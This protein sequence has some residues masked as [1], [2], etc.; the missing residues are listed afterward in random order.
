MSPTNR[1]WEYHPN[2]Y[3]DRVDTQKALSNWLANPD[4]KPI[5][6]LL[7][8]VGVGKS[9]L[10]RHVFDTEYAADRLVLRLNVVELADV[11]RHNDLKKELVKHVSARCRGLSYLLDPGILLSKLIDDLSKLICRQCPSPSPLVLVDGCDEVEQH[12]FAKVEK[13]FFG[14]FV[15]DDASCFRMVIARRVNLANQR[16]RKSDHQIYMQVLNHESEYG[17]EKQMHKAIMHLYPGRNDLLDFNWRPLGVFAYSWNHPFINAF[18]LDRAANYGSLNAIHIKECC[19]ALMN[20]SAD[21]T[22]FMSSTGAEAECQGL[23]KLAVE[24]PDRWTYEQFK[25][26]AEAIGLPDDMSRYLSRGIIVG[27]KTETRAQGPYYCIADGLREL[28]RGLD[29]LQRKE[30]GS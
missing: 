19:M 23:T 11:N 29:V 28:L 12:R 3:V 4:A 26:S 7:G 9:W 2:L 24:L 13:D 20:H 8:S 5:C 22:P 25:Q 27:F 30:R 18:L 14:L 16:L 6:S 1:W 10:L 21:S 15:R 17:F